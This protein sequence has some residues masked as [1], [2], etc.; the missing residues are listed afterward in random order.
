MNQDIKD[1]IEQIKQLGR[2]KDYN[3]LYVP[4]HIPFL[5]SVIDQL[6]AQLEKVLKSG[7][8]RLG[9]PLCDKQDCD[10][11]TNPNALVKTKAAVMRSMTL[12]GWKAACKNHEGWLMN[13][14]RDY[15]QQYPPDFMIPYNTGSAIEIKEDQQ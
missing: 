15:Y 13:Q 4:N 5:L 11:D 8:F 2:D 6:E 9:F 3:I 12:D 10:A 7:S 14:S 1:R